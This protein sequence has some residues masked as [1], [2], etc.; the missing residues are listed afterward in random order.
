MLRIILGVVVCSS[1][2]ALASEAPIEAPVV[3]GTRVPLGKW[4]DAVLVVA[5]DALCTGTL[6][7]PDV[8]LTAG[9]CIEADPVEVITDTVDYAHPGG[10]RIKV[11]WSRAY[12]D[13]QHRYDVG[14]LMLEHVARGRPRA[15]ASACNVREGLVVGA[16]VHVVGFGLAT[17]T[18]TD[19]NTELRE[20]N[21]AVIDPTCTS[22]GACEPAIAPRGEFVAGGRGA[23]TCFGDS[24]GP[25]YLDTPD[26]PALIGVVSRGLSRPGLPCGNEGVYV[27][28][29]K[30]VSWIQSAT[31]AKLERASCTGPADGEDAGDEDA[32]GCEAGS[33][34]G[35][36][37][38]LVALVLGV[39][40]PKRRR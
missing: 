16:A 36:G 24:G 27:R 1:S 4:R 31:K 34:V 29:D 9:H 20:A 25:V 7:A 11:K 35:L 8:V 3:G 22:D 19:H 39:R 38:A 37:V 17:E 12:P 6:V 5:R 15:V 18:A 23:D 28:A 14:I 13:W 30:V 33:G 21:L 32:G 10:D 2:V 26:G 40:R